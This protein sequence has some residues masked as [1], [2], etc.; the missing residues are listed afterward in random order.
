MAQ[1]LPLELLVLD[2]PEPE[3]PTSVETALRRLTF[4]GDLRVLEAA[5]IAKDENGTYER[6]TIDD[7]VAAAD[8]SD[9]PTEPTVLVPREVDGIG[10]LLAPGRTALALV[11]EHAWIGD[12]RQALQ[13]SRGGVLLS[14]ELDAGDV[15]PEHGSR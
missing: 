12:L 3:L 6:H 1:A 15:E 13:S 11:I 10:H 2:F 8:D 9:G 14:V 5:V 7:L 4:L